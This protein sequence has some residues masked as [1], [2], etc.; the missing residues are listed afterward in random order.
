MFGFG[1]L[2]MFMINQR[3]PIS[4]RAAKTKQAK[5]SLILTDLVLLALW[6]PLI[7]WLG[8]GTVLK[9]QFPM[10]VVATTVGVWLFYVQHNFEDTYW[11]LHP[12]WTFEEAAMYGSSY[13]KLPRILQWFSGN[14][15]LHH[16]HHLCPKIPNYLLQT[17]YNE[18][19]Y[20]QNV[21]IL[22]L[23]S[24]LQ[25]LISRLAL[26]D[27]DQKKMVTFGYVH[28]K[29]MSTANG[30]SPEIGASSAA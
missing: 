13:Y 8:F 19:E 9:V 11:R 4:W 30:V 22:T 5:R 29:L 14:I 1:P 18:N 6:I 27:E 21:H 24:S 15:G 10:Y 28:R 7:A 12:E 17:A 16:I 23:S 26:W 25:V 3:T 2:Y 20:F